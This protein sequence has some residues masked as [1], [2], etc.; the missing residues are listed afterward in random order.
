M[1]TLSLDSHSVENVDEESVIVDNHVLTGDDFSI[2]DDMSSFVRLVEKYS[3]TA[4]LPS[5]HWLTILKLQHT[6]TDVRCLSEATRIMKRLMDIVI[7]A[8]ML[9][10]LAPVM[11]L[12]MLLVKL[13]SPGPVIYSQIRVG[14]NLRRPNR[15]RRDSRGHDSV[16]SNRREKA[17][18]RRLDNG[19]GKPF[20]LYKFRT[21]RI[22]AEKN[23]AQLAVKG[24][25]RITPI[26]RLLRKTRIDELP[27]LWNV[28]KGEMSLVGPRPERP[29]FI[30]QLS[31]EIPDYIN[32][33]GLKPGLTGLAQ[34][35]NG[36]DTDIDSIRRKVAL[37][38]L[39]LQNCCIKNDLKILFRTIR[40][41]LTGSGAM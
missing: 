2:D 28:L 23:G 4:N 30:E 16:P 24:D 40:V 20:V 21:M 6:R 37:D 18:D 33:L 13:T 1:T 25:P 27:Q 41:I 35:I 15:D 38:L 36:Y 9:V 26:G 11:L 39:Y 5:S 14:L 34:I 3:T 7:S 29:V 22:D 32:R 10:L 17:N 19:F 31:Q 8:V 12:V